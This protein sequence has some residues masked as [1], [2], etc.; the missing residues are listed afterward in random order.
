MQANVENGCKMGL[1]RPTYKIILP[2]QTDGFSSQ[3]QSCLK[4][5]LA[6]STNT[7]LKPVRV[8]IFL[9]SQNQNDYLSQ[10]QL[11]EETIYEAFGSSCPPFGAVMQEPE[12]PYLVIIEAAFVNRH[13]AKLTY[14]KFGNR[15]YCIVNGNS[16]KEYWN[17]RNLHCN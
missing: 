8:N 1:I 9:K 14:G 11:I 17:G 13:A 15:S 10:T 4:Q 3:W 2:D 16:Y 5:L 6:E 12:D 7:E